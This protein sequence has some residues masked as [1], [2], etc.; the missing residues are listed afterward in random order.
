MEHNMKILWLKSPKTTYLLHFLFVNSPI[1]ENFPN[2]K[3][4][5]LVHTLRP[6]FLSDAIIWNI[7][8]LGCLS[9]EWYWCYNL[10]QKWHKSSCSLFLFFVCQLLW[11]ISNTLE[12]SSYK[13]GNGLGLKRV[14]WY[15]KVLSFM[16]QWKST[17]LVSSL[18]AM[19]ICIYH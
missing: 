10:L 5:L 13:L 14:A 3:I 17:K 11:G 2:Y 6:F 16:T 1:G 9:L 8:L 19:T 4:M 15:V 18:N 7:V 12:T